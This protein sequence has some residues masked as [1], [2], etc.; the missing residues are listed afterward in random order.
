MQL[1]GFMLLAIVKRQFLVVFG[2]LAQAVAEMSNA[3]NVVK[4]AVVKA[5]M[6]AEVVK[7]AVV[8][9][10]KEAVKLPAKTAVKLANLAA[11]INI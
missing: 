9:A 2:F 1:L 11:K 4:A 5:I 3:L 8:K 7:V 10:A 6:N